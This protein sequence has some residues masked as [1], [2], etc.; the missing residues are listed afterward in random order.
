ME[1]QRLG[2]PVT[3]D[4]FPDEAAWEEIDPLPLTMYWPTPGG[5]M[6][7]RTEIRIAYD[8]GYLYAAGWFYESDP[9]GIRG[10]SLYRDRWNGDDAFDFIIDSFN[11]NET[12]RSFTTTP[13][14]IMIDKEVSNDA[15]PSGGAQ[16]LNSEWNTYWDVATQVTEEGWFAE[17]RI[18]FSSLGFEIDGERV[19]MGVIA[20]RY[21]SRL[22]EKHIFP[23]IEP[24]MAMAEFKPSLA[25]DIALV[26]IDRGPPL[27]A[28]PYVLGGVDRRRQLVEPF[29]P[30]GTD[31]TQQVGL[32]V[33]Y[34]LSENL[35]LDLTVN[36]DFAQVEADD[37]VV[38]LSRFNLFF[39]EKRR[40]FQERSSI[41]Q[42]NTGDEG[43]LFHSRRIGLTE[44]GDAVPILAG[45]R[46]TGRVDVWDIGVMSMQ[47]K[48]W[49]GGPGEN[50]AVL[51]VRRSVL[52]GASAIGGMLTSRAM[53]DGRVDLSYGADA[54]LNLFGDEYVTLQ[55]AQSH[56][57]DRLRASNW[58][59][60][61][62]RIFWQRRSLNGLGYELEATRSGLAYE[63]RLG[64]EARND[65]TAFK[66]NFTYGWQPG[67]SSSVNRHTGWLTT[68]LFLRNGDG[69]VQSALQRFRWS[70]NFRGGNFFNVA[71]NFEYEN[72]KERHEFAEDAFVPEGSYFGP[73]IFLYYRLNPGNPLSGTAIVHTGTYLDGWRGRVSI[74]PTWVISPHLTLIPEYT[75]N[76]LWFPSRGQRFDADIVRLRA[77]SAL[78]AHLSTEMFVQY[79]MAAEIVAANI[80]FRYRFSEG[81]DLYLVYDAARDYGLLSQDELRAGRVDQ[82]FLLKYEHTFG[83]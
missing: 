41:F 43:R 10:N 8:E 66:S 22:N 55:L 13:L 56:N 15:D 79:N 54:L 61:L 14:G 81:R 59:R 70:T 58:N 32:D 29:R 60:T 50:D 1:L 9:A 69:S 65:Y 3:L 2:S 24:N 27:Y 46:M 64:F 80:R 42:F 26:G 76:R 57:S 74:Q 11:D 38:N 73:N 82:V 77:R 67:E 30:T 33:K 75:F 21:I 4:G 63:P 83:N 72:L 39:P 20:G 28:T 18:P 17:M 51:R 36:T 52:N 31:V 37:Q 44:D 45:A 53:T 12:A 34:G 6:T 78:N 47:V 40:F 16:P 5:P 19:V 48:E 25:Q 49:A 35:T 71:L 7:E 62:A 68:R 23:A